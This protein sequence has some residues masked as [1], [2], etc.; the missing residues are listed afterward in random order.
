[1][2]NES[3]FILSKIHIQQTWSGTI[4][5]FLY[6]FIVIMN[7]ALLISCFLLLF[8]NPS[9]MPAISQI[10]NFVPLNFSFLFHVKHYERE[11]SCLKAI[12]DDCSAINKDEVLQ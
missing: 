3:V 6:G 8:Y 11:N 2:R 7:Y 10:K 1:M 5:Y 9:M 4:Y 12:A